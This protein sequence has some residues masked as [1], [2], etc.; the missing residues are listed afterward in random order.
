MKFI[1]Q[2]LTLLLPQPLYIGP[3]GVA[4]IAAGAGI[5]GG[6]LGNQGQEQNSQSSSW[7]VL[8]PLDSFSQY[9]GQQQETYFRSLEELLGMG[10][11]MDDYKFGV[12]QQRAYA[13]NPFASAEDTSR[14]NAFS[15]SVF[16]PQKLAI[17]QAYDRQV[18]DRNREAAR[19]GRSSLDPVFNA[20][21]G[22]NMLEQMGQ[23][24]AQQSAF[25]AQYADNKARERVD[26][27]QML[28]QQAQANRQSLL[29]QGNQIYQQGQAYQLNTAHQYGSGSQSSPG[30]GFLAGAL[31]GASTGLGLA[32]MFGGMGGGA[33]S[34]AQVRTGA[35]Q[36]NSAGQ[37][38]A[39]GW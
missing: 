25:S 39:R 22:Q 1:K 32:S 13:R 10:P 15:Q 28:G 36:Y 33:G 6:I 26:L 34:P 38:S 17:N 35:P 23:L 19:L 14:A 31:Q 3:W 12:E 24:G 9:A 11:G 37:Y 8:K 2:F 29:Q 20:K 5:L 27:A 16:A 7:K 4:G 21:L 30:P 18:T